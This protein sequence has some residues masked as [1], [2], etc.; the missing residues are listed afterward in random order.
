MNDS[1]LIARRVGRGRAAFYAAPSYVARRGRPRQL[2]D[3]RHAWV[4]HVGALRLLAPGTEAPRVLVD[5]FV[6]A[7][8]LIRAGMGVG[9]LPA[10][11]ALPYTREGL[12]E[13][14]TLGELPLPEGEIM[15]V[16]PSSGHTPRKVTAFRD[17]L[18]EALGALGARGELGD[19]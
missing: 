9:M 10:A 3:P 12:I 1:T 8:E 7:R 18:V 5:D 19:D 13:S 11:V 6:L 2:G 17:F 4:L 14:V 15:L 16:Y